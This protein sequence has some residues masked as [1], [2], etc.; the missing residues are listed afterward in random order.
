MSHSP[1]PHGKEDFARKALQ[2]EKLALS[3]GEQLCEG[4]TDA[5]C[6][7]GSAYKQQVLEGA[8]ML[9]SGVTAM[10]EL[11]EGSMLY[12]LLFRLML[13]TTGDPK[14]SHETAFGLAESMAEEIN[15]YMDTPDYE[16]DQFEW[17]EYSE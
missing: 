17:F 11:Q 5:D 1:E 8:A 3:V 9:V 6:P 7:G 4:M 12:H 2:F 10:A 16:K 13:S 15:R 14:V